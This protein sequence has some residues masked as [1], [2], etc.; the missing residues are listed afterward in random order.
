MR[1]RK[2]KKKTKTKTTMSSSRHHLR[3]CDY[4][5]NSC[6]SIF[7]SPYISSSRVLLFPLNDDEFSSFL[8]LF[9]VFFVCCSSE[10]ENVN[11]ELWCKKWRIFE[12]EKT[13]YDMIWR[14]PR[15]NN[16][17]NERGRKHFISETHLFIIII[18]PTQ[19][20]YSCARAC[21]CVHNNKYSAINTKNDF[22]VQR[23][24]EI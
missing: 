21:V 12:E 13:L 16:E 23:E 3:S 6:V 18:I 5:E 1:R 9:F 20:E 2:K 8:L 10:W 17:F 7:S 15:F 22:A 11:C 24:R 19:K 4:S 14:A